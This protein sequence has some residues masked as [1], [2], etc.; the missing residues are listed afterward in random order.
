MTSGLEDDPIHA[1]SLPDYSA[2]EAIGGP[3]VELQSA[4]IVDIANA[5]LFL[6]S[7]AAGFTTGA[8]LNVDGGRLAQLA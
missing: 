4:S 5:I 2:G 6:C 3:Q 8:V 7:D 1:L